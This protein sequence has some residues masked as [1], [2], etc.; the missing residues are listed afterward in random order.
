[1]REVARLKAFLFAALVRIIIHRLHL[2]PSQVT[3]FSPSLNG[4]NAFAR[5]LVSRAFFF[6][7][8]PLIVARAGGVAAGDLRICRRHKMR[9]CGRVVSPTLLLFG[10]IITTFGNVAQAQQACEDTSCAV[11][12]TGVCGWNAISGLCVSGGVT[13]ASEIGLCRVNPTV[14]YASRF[15][16]VDHNVTQSGEATMHSVVVPAIASNNC[17]EHTAVLSFAAATCNRAISAFTCSTATNYSN[18]NAGCLVSSDG[19]AA[20]NAVIGASGANGFRCSSSASDGLFAPAIQCGELVAALNRALDNIATNG[21]TGISC[22]AT[23]TT[24][25]PTT[26]TSS[27]PTQAP[28]I[29]TLS[30]STTT[31]SSPPTTT[32]PSPGPVCNPV[33]DLVFMVD[34]SGSV[35]PS[36][37]TASL[38]FIRNTV[39]T[40]TVGSTAARIAIVTFASAVRIDLLLSQGTSMTTVQQTLT[41]M[42]KP[43]GGTNT[44][45]GLGTIEAVVFNTANGMR[46]ISVAPRL[47]VV[48]T[49]GTSVSPTQTAAS[50]AS[51]RNSTQARVLAV[52]VGEAVSMSELLVIASSP[53]DVFTIA[54]HSALAQVVGSVAEVACSFDTSSAAPTSAPNCCTSAQV[55]SQFCNLYVFFS[56]VCERCGWAGHAACRNLYTICKGDVAC[57]HHITGLLKHTQKSL[58][59]FLILS[60]SITNV[61][62]TIALPLTC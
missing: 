10:A 25:S 57:N 50:A 16:C 55:D 7:A 19:P 33:V 30:P 41:G 14:P 46:N 61:I 52:G 59:L 13:D 32:S 31:P 60:T 54:D 53:N 6:L 58:G 42:I 48:L 4:D 49:D 45:L 21:T 44:A 8:H 34:G 24:S 47:L 22:G 18:V 11:N 26:T 37:W 38:N 20:I 39:Q 1:M 28:T 43:G 12:C 29:A 3:L 35:P 15:A 23:T 5:T 9:Y 62:I 27:S 2:D 51:L 36:G 56:R 17:A 40:L